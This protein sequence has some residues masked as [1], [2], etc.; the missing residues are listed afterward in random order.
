MKYNYCTIFDKG[1]LNRGIALHDSVLRHSKEPFRHFILCVDDTTY[2]IL[3]K[4]QLQYVVP[5]RMVDFESSDPKILEAKN[6]RNFL[7]YMWTL[8]SVFTDYVLQNF[9][10]IEYVTYLDADLYFYDSPEIVFNDMKDNSVLIIP[11]NLP[12]WKKEKEETVGK[13]NVGMVIFKNDENGLSCLSWW[14]DEC[15]KWCYEKPEL[16]KLGDQKYLDYFEEKFK[17]VYICTHK[18]ADLAGWNIRNFQGKI[19]EENGHTIIDGDPL[20][21]FHFSSFKLYYPPSTLLPFGPFNSYK[22]IVPSPEKKYIYAEYAEALYRAMEKIRGV[23]PGFTY[24]TL[25]RPSPLQQFTETILPPIIRTCKN[26]L[27]NLFKIK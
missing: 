18:G 17:N 23:Y 3:T 22:Y 2:D 5:I 16:G 8:S 13:Y 1:F 20:I 6:N 14:R 15:L 7:E 12:P 11:H 27:R 21:F 9:K 19:Y 10:E 4:M 26:T 25:P 24:G